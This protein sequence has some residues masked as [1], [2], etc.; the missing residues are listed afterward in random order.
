MFLNI[1]DKLGPEEVRATMLHL[2]SATIVCTI[3]ATMAELPCIRSSRRRVMHCI[4]LIAT[5][6]AIACSSAFYIVAS[7]FIILAIG[8]FDALGMNGQT[9][10]A[11]DIT[12]VYLG[13]LIVMVIL[14]VLNGIS[15]FRS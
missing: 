12:K 5:V 6:I 4:S 15:S 10:A 8:V 14:I 13:F 11:Y 1:L 3:I 7:S 9:G 2:Y